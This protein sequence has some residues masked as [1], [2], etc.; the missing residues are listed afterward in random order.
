MR[1]GVETWGW[2]TVGLTEGFRGEEEGGV[3]AVRM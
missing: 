3:T 1:L 2:G